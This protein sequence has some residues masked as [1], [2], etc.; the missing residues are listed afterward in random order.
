MHGLILG[1]MHGLVLITCLFRNFM[2]RMAARNMS[3]WRVHQ[4]VPV[5]QCQHL[6][7]VRIV[8]LRWRIIYIR[9]CL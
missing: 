6:S 1:K 4:P 8:L 2:H 5:W 9:Y 7:G 3:L